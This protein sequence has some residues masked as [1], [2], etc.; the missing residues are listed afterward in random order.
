MHPL[1]LGSQ[2]FDVSDPEFGHRF[3]EMRQR[4][5]LSNP[6]LLQCPGFFG[7]TEDGVAVA[8]KTEGEAVLLNGLPH[9]SEIA[10]PCFRRAKDGANDDPGGVIDRAMQREF[11]SR[12]S[13]QA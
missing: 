7:R 1:A 9:D 10:F 4:P 11:S 13:N 3:A 8:V 6:F 2:G 12:S 5:W